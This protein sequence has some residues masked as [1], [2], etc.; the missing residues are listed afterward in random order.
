MSP[1]NVVVF[2][3]HKSASMF[4]HHQCKYLCSLAG[5]TYH[6]P[7]MPGSGLNARTLL[8]DRELWKSRRG[9]FAPIRFFVDIP[10]VEDFQ[11]LLHLR[12]PRDVLVSMF[13]S[14]CFIHAGEIPPNTGYRKEAAEQG[15]DA[16]VL[17]KA[18]ADGARYRGDYGTGAHVED[19]IGNVARRY[20]DYVERLLA[21]PNVLLVKYE[22]MVTDY[23]SWLRKFLRPFP[24]E[25]KDRVIDDLI[26]RAP[27]FFPR[28]DGD[29][30]DH[31][32]HIAPGDYRTKLRAATISKLDEIFA[33]TLE[34][35][36]YAR[37]GG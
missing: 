37:F 29:L 12:D 15:I 31:V 34:R 23:G 35:L 26:A 1:P 14:Y 32:R 22:E 13:Y 4:L 19:L 30:M 20:R 36:G 17:A 11:I 25:D 33:D 3:L 18:S 7:N 2:T 28:R 9:C 27:D 24:V 10:N 21:N 5:M 8:T 6:S 16:F